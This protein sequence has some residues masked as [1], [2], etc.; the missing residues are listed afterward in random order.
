M[1]TST[2]YK[3]RNAAGE[4]SKGG[5]SPRFSKKGKIWSGIGPLKLHFN[6]LDKTGRQIY[7]DQQV[8]VETIVITEEC[9]SRSDI[10]PWISDVA[11]R[12][13]AREAET[14]AKVA[15]WRKSRELEELARLQGK[16]PTGT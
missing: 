5:S 7:R 10:E 15:A 4:Y 16:Y 3:L 1:N 2:I 11:E 8:E 14:K 13:A 12:A 6:Q 9:V